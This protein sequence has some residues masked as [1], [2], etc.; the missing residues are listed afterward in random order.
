[1]NH[2]THAYLPNPGRMRELLIPG[3]PLL[4][5]RKESRNRRTSYDT[6]AVRH[7]GVWV[8][9]DSRIP[10]QAIHQALLK[11]KLPEF[12]DYT[13]IRPEYRYGE[14]RLDFLLK[15]SRRV[16]LEVKGCTLVRGGIA[17][18]PDAPTKRG[19][20][21]LHELIKALDDD[22]WTSILFL[23][24]RPDADEFAPNDEADLEFGAALRAADDAGVEVIAYTST[25]NRNQISLG[26]RIPVLLHA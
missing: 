4:L 14:S 17:L 10:N 7:K 2:G 26:R 16:L 25:F 23:V 20:K 6:I 24:Q 15:G 3:I 11:R 9:I 21:H 12:T 13:E 8:C 22:Y 5:M 18:F 19:T 1:M